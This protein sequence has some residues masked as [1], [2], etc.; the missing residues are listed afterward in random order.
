MPEA[1]KVTRFNYFKEKQ[2][3]LIQDFRQFLNSKTQNA[4]IP[5]SEPETQ[6]ED[7][8]VTNLLAPSNQ[9]SV[10]N[11]IRE[12]N[13]IQANYFEVKSQS[14]PNIRIKTDSYN[15]LSQPNPY[16]QQKPKISPNH[17]ERLKKHK[18]RLESIAQEKEQKLIQK[19]QKIENN[20]KSLIKTTNSKAH[21]KLLKIKEK[22]KEQQDAHE[23]LIKESLKKYLEVDKRIEEKREKKFKEQIANSKNTQKDLIENKKRLEIEKEAERHLN[24][25]NKVM[26]INEIRKKAEYK[27]NDIAKTPRIKLERLNH[28]SKKSDDWVLKTE[29]NIVNKSPRSD[30]E[31]EEKLK[32]QITKKELN[33]LI[34]DTRISRNKFRMVVFI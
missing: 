31:K 3:K 5:L 4:D 17:E 34:V 10:S 6:P 12:P 26:K 9:T 11:F 29:R 15:Y 20:T 21:E 18:I 30:N 25:F 8:K 33:R 2:E 16:L 19:L 22:H 7:I 28:Q 27:F 13:E 24:Y 14:T 1:I 32:R 23:Q